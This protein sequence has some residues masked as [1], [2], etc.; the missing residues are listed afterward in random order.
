M[1]WE[2]E[3]KAEMDTLKLFVE[4]ARIFHLSNSIVQQTIDVRKTFKIKLP[5]SIIAATA[6]L[7][8]FTLIA[9]NEKDFQKVTNL[10][11]INPKNI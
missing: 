10:A 5:D 3:D 8:G 6:L 2:T 4:R 7:H 1:V 11:S 9:D